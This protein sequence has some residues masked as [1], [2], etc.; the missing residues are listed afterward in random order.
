MALKALLALKSGH[1]SNSFFNYSILRW[2]YI[3]ASKSAVNDSSTVQC[4]YSV[5]Y[6]RL[7]GL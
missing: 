4:K 6:M 5:G 1:I 2:N 3:S 7:E